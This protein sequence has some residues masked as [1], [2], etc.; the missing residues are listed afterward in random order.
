[1]SMSTYFVLA[2]TRA[3]CAAQV[4]GCYL[5]GLASAR[6]DFH[7]ALGRWLIGL[8]P[9]VDADVMILS[10]FEQRSLGDHTDPGDIL[11][12]G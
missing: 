8:H 7:D 4:L 1:M 2:R 10:L 3:Y 5:F 12:P 6:G 9:N 11:V